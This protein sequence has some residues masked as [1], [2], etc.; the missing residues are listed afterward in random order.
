MGS[1]YRGRSRSYSPP[2]R[3]P[4]RRRYDD[5][6]PPREQPYSDHRRSQRDDRRSPGPS[7]LL[8]RNISLTARSPSSSFTF[9]L[10]FL[11]FFTLLSNLIL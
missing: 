9:L 2:R 8:V 1:S 11:F 5:P 6:P 4:I 10:P 3:S 7:G